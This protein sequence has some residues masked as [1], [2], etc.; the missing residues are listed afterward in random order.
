MKIIRVALL[1]QRIPSTTL[2]KHFDIKA[3]FIRE[4]TASGEVSLQYC[5]TGEMPAD[6]LTKALPKPQFEKLRYISGMR[7][8]SP[9]LI[10]KEGIE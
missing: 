3:H 6:M 2:A 7:T 4:R 10:L 8:T 9:Q 1:L 5:P